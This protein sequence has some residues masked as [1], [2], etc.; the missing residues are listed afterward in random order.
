MQKLFTHSDL[1]E[2]MEHS[3]DT[4]YTH[5]NM[6]QLNKI[7]QHR[8]QPQ[9]EKNICQ[10]RT[11]FWCYQEFSTFYLQKMFTH[12]DLQ[13]SIENLIDT[14]YTHMDML[15]LYKIWQHWRQPQ[16]KK[17]MSKKNKKDIHS[18]WSSR[19]HIYL[20]WFIIHIYG[21]ISTLD[22]LLFI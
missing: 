1:Q 9:T 14:L 19:I 16:T 20:D 11:I 6:F 17:C 3:V 5:M 22:L 4:L 21:H 2:Y 15:Q 7:W 10:R 13:E 18:F 8:R 12:S